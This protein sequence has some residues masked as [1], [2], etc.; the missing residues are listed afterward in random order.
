MRDNGRRGHAKRI[1]AA[2]RMPV[3]GHHSQMTDAGSQVRRRR[4]R[5]LGGAR[6]QQPGRTT[7][8][9]YNNSIRKICLFAGVFEHRLID[10]T[11]S[12]RLCSLLVFLSLLA[13]RKAYSGVQFD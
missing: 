5:F 9:T 6:V 12:R 1:L 4:L 10:A 7:A 13:K 11:F 2:N 8:N 3:H